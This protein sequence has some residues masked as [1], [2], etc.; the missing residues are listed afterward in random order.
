MQQIEREE[1]RQTCQ[2]DA[3]ELS[4]L[5]LP[6]RASEDVADLQIL[7]HLTGDRGG[8][9]HDSGHRKDR[10][11]ALDS[12]DPDDHHRECGDDRGGEGQ[13]RDGIVGGADHADQVSRHCGEEEPG[14]DHDDRGEESGR[15]RLREV[16]VEGDHQHEDQQ[17]PDQQDLE[18]DVAIGAVRRLVRGRRLLHVGDP[19]L[20]AENELVVH[21]PQR[22]GRADQ[23]PADRDGPDRVA[24][25]VPGQRRPV[26]ALRPGELRPQLGTEN[27]DQERHE[28]TPGQEAPREVQRGELGTD[29]VADPQVRRARGRELEGAHATGRDRARFGPQAETDEAL[30]HLANG[31]LEGVGGPEDTA[32]AE[33]LDESAHAHRAEELLGRLGAPL[34]G[35]VD[36]SSGDRLREGQRAVLDHHPPQHRDE[37]DTED[38]ADDHERGGEEVLGEVDR[39]VAPDLEHD[40]SGDREDRSR[41]HRLPDRADG[42][43]E[44]FLQERPLHHAQDRHAD[45]RR[46]IGGGNRHPRP[47]AQVRVGRPQDDA[48]RETQDERPD[49]ELTHVGVHGNVGLVFQVGHAASQFDPDRRAAGPGV[50]RMSRGFYPFTGRAQRDSG[51][52]SRR[53]APR[54]PRPPPVAAGPALGSSTA[55]L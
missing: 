3:R 24:P 12:L 43:R 40:E 53:A 50:L 17:D 15:Q 7:Q 52:P 1:E 26:R 42:P 32:V 30:L 33:Q 13:A 47:K 54:P 16:E 11:H 19:T 37:E 45:D 29:D 49:G 51:V 48:H 18:G 25:E 10:R 41:R 8:D 22:V 27:E 14:E 55:R 21:P 34:A 9:A 39:P 2:H 20:D 6:G 35:L 28:E 31:D 5:H 36:L 44:V 23:H 38:A 46:R 4:H